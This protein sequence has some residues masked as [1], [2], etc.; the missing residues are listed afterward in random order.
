MLLID[1]MFIRRRSG[2]LITSYGAKSDTRMHVTKVTGPR[3]TRLRHC[4]CG[5]ELEA[6]RLQSNFSSQGNLQP[7]M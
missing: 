2:I 5:L 4:G 7:N 3:P 1:C 6:L